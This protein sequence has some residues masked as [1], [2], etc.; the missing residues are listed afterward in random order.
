MISVAAGVVALAWPDITAMV[1]TLCV[2]AWAFMTGI[3]EVA[4]A[5]RRGEQAGER[6]LWILGGLV[7]MAFGAVLAVR[8]DE[9]AVTLA[10][11]FGMFSIVSGISALVLSAQMKRSHDT[12]ERLVD[13]SMPQRAPAGHSAH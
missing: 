10:I 12:A 7:S 9:G 4:L 1:L 2:G 11:V 6:A 13:S 8:P 5:F 3:L